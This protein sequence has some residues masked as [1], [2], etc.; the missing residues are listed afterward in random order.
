MIDCY[1]LQC[2]G[3][4]AACVSAEKLES[5]QVKKMVDQVWQS[6]LATGDPLEGLL[7]REK[8]RGVWIFS[9]NVPLYICHSLHGVS[10]DF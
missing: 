2:T 8:V 1:A 4:M 10:G 9:N 7:H 6:R 5:A 3:V